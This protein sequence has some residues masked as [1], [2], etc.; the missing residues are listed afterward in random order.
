MCMAQRIKERRN[1]LGLTQEELGE[2][3]GLQKSAIAKYENGR[4]E[5]IKRSV[6]AKMADILEC[7]PAY[8]MGWSN[9]ITGTEN[10]NLP[11]LS[12]QIEKEYGKAAASALSLYVQLDELDRLRVNERMQTLLENEKYSSKPKKGLSNA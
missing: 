3:L 2:K 9:S 11:S 10:Q 4:V 8:L 1:Y 12:E 7:S 5:N 6:I